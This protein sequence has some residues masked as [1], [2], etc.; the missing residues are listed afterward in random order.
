MK[1]L[2]ASH[3][4]A[5]QA[6]THAFAICYKVTWV[7]GD[8]LGYTTHTR[9]L[10]IGGVTYSPL[11]GFEAS[12]VRS[13]STGAVEGLEMVGAAVSPGL[14]MEDVMQEFWDAAKVEVFEVLQS[15]Y[16]T[17]KNVLRTGYI[18][19]ID[20]QGLQATA[21]VRSLGHTMQQSRGRIVQ[22]DCP[23][24]FADYPAEAAPNIRCNLNVASYKVTGTLDS[25]SA[26][27]DSYIDD[28]VCYLAM[29]GANDSTQ[30][31]D[32]A[33]HDWAINGAVVIKN[34]QSKFGGVS[35]YFAA[36]GSNLQ[37]EDH[38]DFDFGA[39]DFCIEGWIWTATLPA[40]GTARGILNKRLSSATDNSYALALDGDNSGKLMFTC[41]TSGTA[42]TH[43]ALS[44]SAPALSGWA[45]V[46][47]E[48]Y[49]GNLT[50]YLDGVGGT[51]VSIGTT[52]LFSNAQPVQIG[53]NANS[54][55]ANGWVGYLDMIRITR[56]ARYRGNF[57]PPAVK[58]LFIGCDQTQYRRF[59]YDAARTETEGLFTFGI[60]K[61]TSGL[62]NGLSS[63][64]KYFA[65]GGLI[66]LVTPMPRPIAV[67]DTYEMVRGCSKKKP[68]CI[69]FGNM[70]NFQG[71]PNVPTPNDNSKGPE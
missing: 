35:A 31:I 11:A 54:D 66:E 63:A 8:I 6:A 64:V 25:I 53:Q 1:T 60:F 14:T 16:A 71:F 46:A 47:I 19:S 49:N 30:F 2:P 39:S 29:D 69:A 45:H 5:N 42:V 40:A 56:N 41:S 57:T 51:P 44:A 67:G 52:A 65:S 43:T 37:T 58:P 3:T 13:G 24:N 9:S 38:A 48:R 10:V 22:E 70:V 61:L 7:D 68:A 15:D 17:D 50:V 28:T 12:N 62:N 59:A 55:P 23:A 26:A 32:L 21:E 33:R 27:C 4:A 20:I 18:G 36:T 34:T